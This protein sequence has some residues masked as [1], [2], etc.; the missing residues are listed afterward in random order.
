MLCAA[1]LSAGPRPVLQVHSHARI[2]IAGQAPGSKVHKTGVPFDAPCGDRLRLW[3]GIDKD[4]FY[5]WHLRDKAKSSLTETL[6]AWREYWPSMLLL[7]HPSPRNNVWLKRNGW[8]EGDV[9]P[10]LRTRV[11]KLL[12]DVRPN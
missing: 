3:L 7:P 9:L 2:L 1:S 11:A 10:V 6:A 8:F 5:S 12:T 4:A